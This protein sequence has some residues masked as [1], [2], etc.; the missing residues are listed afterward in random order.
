[1]E[2]KRADQDELIEAELTQVRFQELGLTQGEQVFV[3]PRNVRVFLD[4]P[5]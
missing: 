4:K 3:Y 2:L 5:S 1:L